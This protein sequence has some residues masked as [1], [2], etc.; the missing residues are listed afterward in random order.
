MQ[1]IF[2]H[3]EDWNRIFILDFA[4]ISR[5]FSF[6]PRLLPWKRRTICTV[7]QLIVD[8]RLP[9]DR[10]MALGFID[11]LIGDWNIQTSWKMIGDCWLEYTYSMKI[12]QP[13]LCWLLIGDCHSIGSWPP[14]LSMGWLLIG[15]HDF[16]WMTI[17]L[18]STSNHTKTNYLY[19]ALK[20]HMKEP[21]MACQH[22]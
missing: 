15:I 4:Y 14:G 19:F 8:W 7:T 20:L 6:D 12:G 16:I 3:S 1:F 22:S 11:G 9:F 10:L 13:K 2:F 18:T 21:I 17:V 5:K